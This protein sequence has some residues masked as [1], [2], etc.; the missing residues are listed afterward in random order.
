MNGFHLKA[1]IVSD[2]QCRLCIMSA[3]KRNLTNNL[4]LPLKKRLND[5]DRITR[6]FVFS[7]TKESLE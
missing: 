7:N 4:L 3:S 5:V 2:L 1:N 6:P